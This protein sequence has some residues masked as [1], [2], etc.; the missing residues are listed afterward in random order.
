MADWDAEAYARISEPQFAWGKRVLERLALR[1]D[2]TVEDAGCGAGRLTEL[3]VERLSRG[4][5]VAVDASEAMLQQ[6]SARLARFGDRV[7]FVRADLANHVQKPP[8]DALFSTATLH[9]VLDHG[10]L[11]RSLAASLRSGGSLVAQFGGGANIARVCGRTSHLRAEPRFARYFDGWK[12]PWN[13]AGA[14][15]T[16]ARLAASG[17]VDVR[18]WLAPAPARFEGATAFGEFV[19]KVVLRDEL[20]R[21][22]EADLRGAYVAAVVD[23]ASRDDPPFELDYVRL[24]VDA[25]RA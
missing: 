22:P 16:A 1:G 19:A 9:W 8:V 25:R 10:A 24:D 18:A 12:S 11:F 13:F 6:A 4:R 3:L 14:E 20:A 7:K 17:F 15:E 21:L 2:E 5:V 23:A